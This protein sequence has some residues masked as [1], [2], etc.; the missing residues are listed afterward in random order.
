MLE[1][2]RDANSASRNI[3]STDPAARWTA[4]PGGPAFYAYS[5]NHLIDLSAGIIMD[6]EATPAHRTPEVDS[7]RTMID[8][9]EQRFNIKTRRLVGDTAYGTTPLLGW[10]VENKQIEPTCLCGTRRHARMAA[11]RSVSSS[12]SQSAMST[13]ALKAIHCAMTGAS[14]RRREVTHHEIGSA[15]ASR[16]QWCAGRILD[17]RCSPEPQANGKVV[18][19]NRSRCCDEERMVPVHDGIG[20]WLCAWRCTRV[21]SY[22]P[23]PAW[24]ATRAESGATGRSLPGLPWQRLGEAG[25]ITV[26]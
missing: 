22:G 21:G 13:F 25:V 5:T 23:T 3:S 26:I 1:E 15:Q 14:S 10:M 6:V 8:R 19:A 9:V 16:P 7:T 4:A 20:I 2:T 24:R 12:G 18:D 11:F 17:G